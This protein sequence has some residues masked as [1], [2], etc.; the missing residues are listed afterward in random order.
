MEKVE[1]FQGI[2]L[3]GKYSTLQ[4]WEKEIVIVG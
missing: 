3:I 2:I 4:K 1:I